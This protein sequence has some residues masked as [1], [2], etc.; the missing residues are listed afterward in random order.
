MLKSIT[1]TQEVLQSKKI[2]FQ[3][4]V[5]LSP[6]LSQFIKLLIILEMLELKKKKMLGEANFVK[7]SNERNP[8]N[9]KSR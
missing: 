5:Y 6:L 3:L 2:F 8:E 1:F 7:R 4:R 9:S